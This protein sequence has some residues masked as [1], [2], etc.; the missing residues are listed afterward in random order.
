MMKEPQYV[1]KMMTTYGN[2]DKVDN[3]EISRRYFKDY[4]G[5]LVRQEIKYTTVF[6]NHFPYR[7][8]TDDHHNQRHGHPSF[9]ET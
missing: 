4:S 1:M 9:K 7:H 2:L 8:A 6:G 3:Q 5:K